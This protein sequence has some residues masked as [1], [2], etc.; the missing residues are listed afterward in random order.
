VVAITGLVIAGLVLVGL[1]LVIN[2]D[3]V[4]HINYGLAAG[5]E[6]RLRRDRFVREWR[7]F[8]SSLDVRS[9][10]TDLGPVRGDAFAGAVLVESGEGVSWS[11]DGNSNSAAGFV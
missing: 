1:V 3:S 5:A 9:I 7:G 8:L 6:R 10:M 2:H 11:L 4:Y